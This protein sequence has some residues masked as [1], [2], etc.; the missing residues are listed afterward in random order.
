MTFFRKILLMQH[1]PC[2]FA[3]YSL[4]YLF[5]DV[6]IETSKYRRQFYFI[7]GNNQPF[8]TQIPEWGFAR[9]AVKIN[10]FLWQCRLAGIE[11]CHVVPS[12]DVPLVAWLA[13]IARHSPLQCWTNGA[14]CRIYRQIY[15]GLHCTISRPVSWDKMR[16]RRRNIPKRSM[17]CASFL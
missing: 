11:R 7:S 14:C 5:S 6:A 10:R 15:R 3:R 4:P 9:A 16:E 8:D 1:L 17:T 2:G 12:K 13:E